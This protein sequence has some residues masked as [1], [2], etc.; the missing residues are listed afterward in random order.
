MNK[1]SGRGRSSCDTRRRNTLG[2]GAW[3]WPPRSRLSADRETILQPL[4]AVIG[5]VERRQT[6][7]ILANVHA[8][9]KLCARRFWRCVGESL[10]GAI[11]GDDGAALGGEIGGLVGGALAPSSIAMKLGFGIRGGAAGLLGGYTNMLATRLL[12][13]VANSACD[14]ICSK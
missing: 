13:K 2:S 7:P 14:S 12:T 9:P 10:G 3:R 1:H 5:V 11:G 8:G 6:M 4:Q